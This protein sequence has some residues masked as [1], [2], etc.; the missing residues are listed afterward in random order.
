MQG[1]AAAVAWLSGAPNPAHL[2]IQGG[3]ERGW[4]AVSS[5]DGPTSAWLAFLSELAKERVSLSPW[6]KGAGRE[7]RGALDAQ[8]WKGRCQCWT[9]GPPYPAL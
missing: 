9:L 5:T 2:Y 1:A 8:E 7:R 4:H 6:A 3:G